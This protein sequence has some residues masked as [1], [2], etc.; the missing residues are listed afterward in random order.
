MGELFCGPG[1]I[2]CGARMAHF[3]DSDGEKWGI[4]HAW[5]TDYDADTCKTYAHN[6][7]AGK[8]DSV[9]CADIRDLDLTRLKKISE[10]DA[11]AFGFPCNDFSTVGEQKGFS[12]KYGPL[13]QY[14][15]SALNLFRPKWFFAENVGGLR[16]AN[17]GRA[18]SVILQAMADAGYSL[19]PHYYSFDRYGVPQSRQRIVI[20]GIR[21]D[22]DLF[23][24]IPSPEIYAGVDISA[25]TALEVPPI[26]KRAPNQERTKQSPAVVERLRYILPGQNAFN[27]KLPDKLKL[28]VR[29]AKISQ[30]YKRLDPAKP[31]YTVTGSGGGG[32]HIYHWSEPR[33][34][35]NRERARLQTFPDDYAFCGSK[36]SVRKQIGMAVPC[37]GAKAIF[38]A[39]LCTFAGIS[40]P[41]VP[42]TFPPM[43]VRDQGKGTYSY[44]ALDAEEILTLCEKANETSTSFS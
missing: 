10:I 5:A 43:I 22:I 23:F 3:R 6:I 9:I 42:S 11:L 38:D 16:S 13:Y 21:S 18:F 36:E 20:V 14:G 4:E 27:A 35:T 19:F 31:A 1:G 2:A 25:K 7:C 33:A 8:T 24:K 26:P 41:S 29:G 15:V 34:L 12:G 32:T 30:I 28:N 44:K 37:K 17:S 40:Y 39:V